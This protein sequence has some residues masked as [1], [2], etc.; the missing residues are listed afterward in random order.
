[1][2]LREEE[3]SSKSGAVALAAN[4]SNK[5]LRRIMSI[6]THPGF[7]RHSAL[8]QRR[9]SPGRIASWATWQLGCQFNK[10]SLV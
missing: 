2:P 10:Y 8:E 7:N 9:R 5:K 4:G 1:M 3:I 6:P